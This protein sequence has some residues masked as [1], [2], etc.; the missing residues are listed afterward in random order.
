MTSLFDVFKQRDDLAAS[1]TD[2]GA[3]VCSPTDVSQSKCNDV[4]N[5]MPFVSRVQ[6]T[7]GVVPVQCTA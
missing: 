4:E 5:V 1:I 6:S 2:R 7:K 3:D